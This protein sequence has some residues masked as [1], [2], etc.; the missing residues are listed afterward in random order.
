MTRR[1]LVPAAAVLAVVL[2][3]VE[4]HADRRYYGTTYD[5]TTSPPGGFDVELWTTFAQP[6][7]ASSGSPQFWYHQIELETGITSRWDV[8]LYN[9]F[10]YQQ[11]DTTRYAAT[12]L[13]TRYRLS[14]YGQWFVDPVLYLELRQEWI[15]DKPF[16]VEGQLVVAKA[17]ARLHIPVD[18][19]YEIEFIPGGQ[20]EHEWNY[21][22]GTSY[23]LVPWFRVGGE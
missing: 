17:V 6:P 21:A 14:D 11:A 8:A 3:P 16:A 1:A 7:R 19:S 12:R 5:A 13:E 22:A 10:I 20:L 23:E 9:D 4:A 18:G 2:A 15:E